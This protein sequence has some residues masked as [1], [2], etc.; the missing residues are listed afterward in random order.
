MSTDRTLFY[1]QVTWSIGSVQVSLTRNRVNWKRA[2]VRIYWHENNK[3]HRITG[4]ASYHFKVLETEC[5]K[6]MDLD[7]PD[8]LDL[9]WFVPRQCFWHVNGVF[10]R[11]RKNIASF[12]G[13][14]RIDASLILRRIRKNPDDM[15]RWIGVAKALG[16]K[17]LEKMAERYGEISSVLSI[18]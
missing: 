7:S 8:E 9:R 5:D 1:A 17:G 2:E 12:P 14:I 6:L 13:F 3:L 10:L 4:P 16:I 18:I 15:A 11:N